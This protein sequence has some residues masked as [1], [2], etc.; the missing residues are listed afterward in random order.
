MV[1]TVTAP[2][3]TVLTDCVRQA[4]QAPS[5][6]NS[7]PWR[8]RLGRGRIDVYAD[9]GRR[10]TVLDPAARE[11][12]MSVGAAVFTAR[13]A[14]R[15]AGFASVVDLFPDAAEPDLVARLTAVRQAPP[16]AVAQALAEA[17]GRRHTNRWPF[18]RAAVPART[19]A[20]LQ[21]AARR[22]GTELG[23]VGP[24]ARHGVLDLA[25]WA[26]GRLRMM[27]GYRTELT[28]WVAGPPSRRDGVPAWA[29]G[30]DDPRAGV[31]VRHFAELLPFPLPVGHFETEPTVLL[32]STGG[33]TVF[34]HIAAGQALQ[35][36]LLTATWLGLAAMPI[37]QPL[38]L[39]TTRDKLS[40]TG[41]GSTAQILL[42]VGYGRP[43]RATPRRPLEDVLLPTGGRATTE[44]PRP[45][46]PRRWRA[47]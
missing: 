13:L 18:I 27:P 26:D 29:M 24:E 6:H 28:R 33:D 5:L 47:R 10:L 25:R 39:S 14:L 34:E 41:P 12:M 15:A 36:V 7:Q 37:S 3:R 35:R 2:H 38:E 31:P 22:E 19:V 17:V 32:L 23:L 21:D 16:T 43:V 44:P 8:F 1:S 46:R 30:P 11:L 40:G 45:A 9:R 4:V 42:R 20:A